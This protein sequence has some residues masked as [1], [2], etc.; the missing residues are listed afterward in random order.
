M[1]AA[2]FAPTGLNKQRF[3]ITGNQNIVKIEYEGGMFPGIDKGIIKHHFEVGAG[4]DNF[5][6]E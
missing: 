3:K 6:W 2:L 1:E 5:S 4:K